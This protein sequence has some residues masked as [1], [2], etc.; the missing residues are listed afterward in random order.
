M[1]IINNF[2]ANAD[3][4]AEAGYCIYYGMT[5]RDTIRDDVRKRMIEGLRTHDVFEI[6]TDFES[7]VDEYTDNIMSAIENANE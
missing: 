6:P 3:Y 7:D 1:N 2:F 4:N 5:D